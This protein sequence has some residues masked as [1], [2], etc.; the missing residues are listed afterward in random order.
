MYEVDRS[1]LIVAHDLHPQYVSSRRAEMLEAYRRVAVQHHHAHIASVLAEHGLFDERVIGVSFDGTGYG[2]DGTIWGSE[3]LLGSLA[4]GFVRESSLPPVPM[5]G[6][7]AA[8]RH[9][10]QAAAAFLSE[11][12]DLPDLR[13]APFRFPQRYVD[14]A[15]LIRRNVRCFTSTSAGRLFDAAA[16]LLGFTREISFEGQA[17]I[18]LEHLAQRAP[19]AESYAFAGLDP[20]PALRR[21]IEDRLA[22]RPDRADRGGI[23]RRDGGGGG[24]RGG[25]PGG[26]ER[27]PDGRLLRR[28]LA[29]R[30]AAEP[31]G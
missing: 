10:V 5:P 25:A 24:G 21:M 2:L 9:P 8:A 19:L 30:T 16:A 23:P 6:G 14:A 4:E 17:A 22:G 28:C 31:R 29:E 12:E 3:F 27:S 1:A 26:V 15:E 18:W 11:M 7:D 13:Q 20:R